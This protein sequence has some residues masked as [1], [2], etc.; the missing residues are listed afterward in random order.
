[1][2]KQAL[3]RYISV[4]DKALD[5][6]E[7]RLRLTP[8]KGSNQVRV[9][10]FNE[11]LILNL[12]RQ[13][14]QLTKAEATRATGLSPNAISMIFRA[15][16][17]EKLLLRDEP[18]RGKIGQP[19]TPLRLNPSARHYV[20]LKI[21]RRSFDLV[22]IDFTGKILARK[23]SQHSHPTPARMLAFFRD[24]VRPLLRTAHLRRTD[25]D[26]LGVAVPSDI[27]QWTDDFDAP[28]AEMEAWRDFDVASA[29]HKILP[30]PVS[31]ENDGTAACRAELVFGPHT[32]KQDVIYFFI[33][34]LIGGGIVLNGRV[35]VGRRGNSG[36]FGPLRVPDEPGGHRLVDHASLV[37]LEKLIS[38]QG[39]D[40]FS[41]YDEEFVW[42]ALEPA[43]SQWISR[44]ARSLAHAIISSLSVIDFEAVVI[45]GAMPADCRSRLL[46]EIDG[47]LSRLDLQGVMHPDLSSGHF[48]T[49][50]RALGA[51]S[52]RIATD[53]MID[54]NALHFGTAN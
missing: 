47:E 20:G 8:V 22:V 28:K 54:Q 42:T 36:G 49:V 29:L 3:V 35:Y 7:E 14:G 53:F 17:D 38:G 30:V 23:T 33:G 44:A 37:V 52:Y 24:E 45:D 26:A 16:E 2:L 43:L 39:Q 50:A 31:I 46:R 5:D 40:P 18:I 11:R 10:G 1:M 27:W 13:Y 51:A 25:I 9:R 12:I 34:T 32:L 19:S 21:G 48:G 6:K 15:L 4:Q 41:I